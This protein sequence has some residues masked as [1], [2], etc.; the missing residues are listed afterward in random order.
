MTG[1]NSLFETS[2]FSSFAATLDAVRQNIY[3]V[4]RHGEKVRSRRQLESPASD[5]APRPSIRYSGASMPHREEEV[6]SAT[7]SVLEITPATTIPEASAD[8]KLDDFPEFQER[9]KPARESGL[10]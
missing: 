1:R 6:A 7:Q 8:T 4:P 2:Y 5:C 3:S 9:R 10:R